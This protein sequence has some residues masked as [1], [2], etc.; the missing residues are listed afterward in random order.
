VTVLAPDPQ[1]SPSPAA[2]AAD[3]RRARTIKLAAE[4]FDDGGYANVS[5]EQI[6]V[7]AGIA[8]PTLY[9][10][11]GAKDE[12]LRGIHE[13]FIDLLLDRQQERQK[14]AMTPREPAAGRDDRHPRPHGDA[15][16]PRPGLLRALQGAARPGAPG[17]SR[18]A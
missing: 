18:Q 6:A 8:K 3:L 11:F 4:L 13:A 16:W 12:I 1:G 17:N 10:Y 5:M 15:P 9:H 7:A 2:S 14:L